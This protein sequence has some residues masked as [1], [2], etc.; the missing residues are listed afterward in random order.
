MITDKQLM[1]LYNLRKRVQEQ[2][3]QI[4]DLQ[5]KISELEK[6]RIES[7]SIYDREEIHHNCTVQILHNTITGMTEIGW[8]PEGRFEDQTGEDEEE[9][10]EDAER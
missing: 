3:K 10:E 1:E 4:K 2:R 7:I 8:W 5:K 6:P 9:E